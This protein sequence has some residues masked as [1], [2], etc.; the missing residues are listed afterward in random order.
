MN[1]S[2]K[3]A[4]VLPKTDHIAVVT[5]DIG[6]IDRRLLKKNEL[7]FVR[8]EVKKKSKLISVNQY[9]RH[10][11]ICL[12]DV[13]GKDEHLVLEA[14]RRAGDSLTAA[15]NRLKAGS[16]CVTSK[17]SADEVCA[18]AEGMMLGN[19]QFLKY[20]SNP[21]NNSLKKISVFATTIQQKEL[22]H[23]KTICEAVCHARDLV[24]EPVIS[25]NAT[26]LANAFKS[27]GKDAGFSVKVLDKAKIKEM[28]M[29]GLLAVNMGSIDPPTFTIME[30]KPA[31]HINTKPFV[32]VG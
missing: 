29:G 27:L 8:K 20:K 30:W 4:N 24:N 13:N 32:L 22:D 9:S 12:V 10:V 17:E 31:K 23:T 3:K 25:L 7:E 16:V 15:L 14:Y 19:Y 21:E 26:D 11:F 5:T 28:K 18:F 6:S 2:I 1:L